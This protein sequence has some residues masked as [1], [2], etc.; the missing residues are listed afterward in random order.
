[1]IQ[2]G[3]LLLAGA[4]SFFIIIVLYVIYSIYGANRAKV[5]KEELAKKAA[6]LEAIKKQHAESS[7]KLKDLIKDKLPKNK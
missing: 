1:M 4:F 7:S 5:L 2:E 3:N 6:E